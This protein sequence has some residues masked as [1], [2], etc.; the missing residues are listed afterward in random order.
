V[1]NRRRFL[2][3]ASA[4]SVGGAWAG[5]AGAAT[6]DDLAFANFGA[7]AE[8]LL[9]DFYAKALAT[10]KFGDA[11]GDVLRQGRSIAA[12]HARALGD[13]LTGAGDSA[14]LAE[15]FQFVWPRAAFAGERAT[16]RTGVSL[17]RPLLGTYQTAAASAS[18]P[19]YR[20]LFASLSASL[21]QQTATLS[22]LHA[23]VAAEPFP[24]ATDLEAASAALEP[25]LG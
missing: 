5:S 17:L 18:V 13:L 24:V 7:S 20:V 9:R 16:V 25:Y 11:R 21:G 23:P 2:A 19:S 6:E 4:L 22:A 14:P 1:L 8:L 3:G 10:R 12:Q 15:D